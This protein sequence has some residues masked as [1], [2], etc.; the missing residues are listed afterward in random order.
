MASTQSEIGTL[1]DVRALLQVREEACRAKDIDRLMALY[2]PDSIYYD[3]VPLLEFIGS[4]AIRRN[5]LRWFE[6]Y[7]GSIGLETHDLHIVASED[8]AFAHMLHRDSALPE[9]QIGV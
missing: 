1:T 4:A 6:E 9:I 5:F 7:K 2:S 3:V 8:V